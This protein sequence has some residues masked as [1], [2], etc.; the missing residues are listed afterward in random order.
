[1]EFLS[2]LALRQVLKSYI[3]FNALFYNAINYST[4]K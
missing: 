3:K 1:M 2:D 4:L